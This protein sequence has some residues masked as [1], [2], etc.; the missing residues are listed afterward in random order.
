[1]KILLLDG[2]LSTNQELQ[3]TLLE[4]QDEVRL[5]NVDHGRIVAQKVRGKHHTDPFYRLYWTNRTDLAYDAEI[6][7]RGL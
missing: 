2:K 6:G 1:M 3:T 5:A 7:V 4:A